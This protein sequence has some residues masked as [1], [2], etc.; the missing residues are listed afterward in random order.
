MSRYEDAYNR[1]LFVTSLWDKTLG[2]SRVAQVTHRRA[3]ILPD[4]PNQ[5][6]VAE[7]KVSWEYRQASIIWYVPNVCTIDDAELERIVVHEFVHVLIAPMEARV[8]DKFVKERE[9]AVQCLTDAILNVAT[10]RE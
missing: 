9:F 8:P 6:I 1:V 5:G 4:E 2:V 7:T 3:D 10:N